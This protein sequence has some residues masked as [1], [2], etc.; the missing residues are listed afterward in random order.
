M[1]EFVPALLP[2]CAASTK[3][4]NALYDV[5]TTMGRDRANPDAVETDMLCI[6]Q[7][8]VEGDHHGFVVELM[9]ADCGSAWTTWATGQ[10]PGDILVRNDCAAAKNDEAC[11]SYAGHPGG[12]T[13]EISNP[14]HGPAQH[15]HQR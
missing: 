7:A 10:E 11:C 5:I 15:G 6:L 12:H 3:L 1:T 8:H 4:P 14:W 13:Y 9:G 2:H